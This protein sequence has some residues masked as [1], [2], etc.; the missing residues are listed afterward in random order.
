[1]NDRPIED[2]TCKTIRHATSGSSLRS[3]ILYDDTLHKKSK[4]NIMDALAPFAHDRVCG[5]A[6]VHGPMI[7]G[8]CS[9]GSTTHMGNSNIKFVQDE[10]RFLNKADSQSLGQNS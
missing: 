9:C 4:D 8:P 6:M 10:Q 2:E 1:M 7:A 5:M 3:I